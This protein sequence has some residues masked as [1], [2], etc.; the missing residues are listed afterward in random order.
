MT[1]IEMRKRM[2]VIDEEIHNLYREKEKYEEYFRNKEVQDRMNAH[3]EHVGKC[4]MAIDGLTDNSDAH[5]V[6]FKILKVLDSPNENYAL[7]VAL[8][9]GR[10]YTCWNEYGIQVMTLELWIPNKRRMDDPDV[11]DFYQEISQEEFTRLYIKH[12]NNINGKI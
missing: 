2:K 8:I 6:A 7:C 11:I 4:Y 3:K 12:S 9:D 1:E 5:V 10:R